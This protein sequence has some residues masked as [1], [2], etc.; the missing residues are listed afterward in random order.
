MA[1]PEPA[2]SIEDACIRLIGEVKAAKVRWYAKFNN[3]GQIVP[4][5]AKKPPPSTPEDVAKALSAYKT[6]YDE[7]L[8]F[9]QQ[10]GAR[11]FIKILFDLQ[12]PKTPE[13]SKPWRDRFKLW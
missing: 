7:A 2:E 10:N 1:K 5:G 4:K 6:R 9:M 13:P 3:L 11:E 12:P 8:A